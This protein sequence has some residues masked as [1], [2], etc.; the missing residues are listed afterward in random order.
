MN[1]FLL[2]HNPLARAAASYDCHLHWLA[3]EAA[4]LLSNAR[5]A[6]GMPA[7][8]RLAQPHHPLSVWVRSSR[9]AYLFTL[10]HGLALL[11]EYEY[12]RGYRSA[13]MDEVFAALTDVPPL[14]DMAVTVYPVCRV[15]HPVVYVPLDEA[16]VL[17]REYYRTKRGMPRATYTRRVAPDW[18]GGSDETG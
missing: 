4:Q 3:K 15:G 9:E 17:Y 6:A 11:D 2:D 7:P 13:R 5:L 1:I 12:R 8:Y 14:P 16:V 18:L 10:T